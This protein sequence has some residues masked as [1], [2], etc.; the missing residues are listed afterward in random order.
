M[1]RENSF[2]YSCILY[3]LYFET[4]SW[5]L[6]HLLASLLHNLHLWLT[7]LQKAQV[8]LTMKRAVIRVWTRTPSPGLFQ[9]TGEVKTIFVIL[10]RLIYPFPSYFAFSP[11]SIPSLVQDSFLEAA[12]CVVTSSPWQQTKNVLTVLNFLSLNF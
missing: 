7:T 2:Q 10:L 8:V 9:G 12:W 5:L 3:K 6:F 1:Q 4:C 11:C